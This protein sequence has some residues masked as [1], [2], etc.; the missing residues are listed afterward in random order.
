[1]HILIIGQV[2]NTLHQQRLNQF[3]KIKA[4]KVL[5]QIKKR[6]ISKKS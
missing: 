5:K 4:V 2:Q 3:T 1:M 6:V